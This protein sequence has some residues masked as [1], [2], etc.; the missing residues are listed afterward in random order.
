MREG[1]WDPQVTQSS[2]IAEYERFKRPDGLF[3][4][5]F[6]GFSLVAL[7]MLWAS[8]APGG[9][10]PTLPQLIFIEYTLGALAFMVT[11][12][13]SSTRTVRHQTLRMLLLLNSA[14]WQDSG[15]EEEAK[16][17]ATPHSPDDPPSEEAM[18]FREKGKTST[19]MMA[20]MLTSAVLIITQSL[21]RVQNTG[22]GFGDSW[23]GTI[24]LLAVAMGALAFAFLV[25]A[26]DAIENTFHIFQ[27]HQDALI[28]HFHR[29]SLR[30]KYDGI[31]CLILTLA[32]FIAAL[33][34]QIGAFILAA[35]FSVGY[36]YW[37]TRFSAR[38]PVVSAVVRWA[39]CLVPLAAL[40]LR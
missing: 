30:P 39:V 18:Q 35:T 37:F 6:A 5:I 9:W 36:N 13:L 23:A 31:M 34:P 8:G 1:R 19:T 26:I 38:P 14:Q 10:S 22:E 3:L 33:S 27:F 17:P 21:L 25:V 2:P 40:V 16:R 24:S 7:G 20:L 32:L 29:F 4:G 28:R 15:L 11:Y 12:F